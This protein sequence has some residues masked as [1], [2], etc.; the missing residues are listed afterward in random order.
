MAK[1]N[2]WIPYV[3]EFQS[4]V[5]GHHVYKDIWTPTLGGKLSTTREP[6]NHYDKYTMKVSKENEVV[7]HVPRDISKYCTR[8]VG[9]VLKSHVNTL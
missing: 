4:Y 3:F 7:G 1:T 5:T 6:E 2:V 9:M 8:N